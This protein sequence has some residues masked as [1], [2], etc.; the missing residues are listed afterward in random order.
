MFHFKH[1]STFFQNV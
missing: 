1:Q